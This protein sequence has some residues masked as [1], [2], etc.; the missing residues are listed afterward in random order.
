[1]QKGLIGVIVPVYKVE[2]YIAECIESILAQTYTNFRLILVDDGTPDNAGKI[3][4]EYAQNDPRITVIHQE[5]AG[6]TGA[7]ARGVEEAS[8]CEYITFVD[9]DDTLQE[10]ALEVLAN[11]ISQEVDIV[12]GTFRDDTGN[13]SIKKQVLTKKEYL[14]LLIP[15]NTRIPQAPW[16]KL[17]KR[18]LFSEYVFDIPKTIIVGEDDIM[19]IRLAANTTG[20]ITYINRKIYNYRIL[21]DSTIH[22]FRSSLNYQTK[23]I[24]ILEDSIPNDIYEDALPYITSRLLWEW[25]Q[26]YRYSIKE[27]IRE[28]LPCINLLKKLIKQS[29]YKI[30]LFDKVQLFSSSKLIKFISI[31][32]HI[33]SNILSNILRA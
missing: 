16:G 19:N 20:S 24:K 26:F 22:S 17:F 13:E 33:I 32:I 30:S 12:V 7:R 29:N 28:D 5:N 18:T 23:F 3:C 4:D 21:P 6:V 31:K 11:N 15:M 27:T 25:G 9:G 8:D 10:F 1:M 14:L 2:K